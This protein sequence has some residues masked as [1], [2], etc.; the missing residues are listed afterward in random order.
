V[1]EKSNEAKQR[2]KAERDENV[3]MVFVPQLDSLIEEREK[4]L[5][6]GDGEARQRSIGK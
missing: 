5:L 1:I 6:D 3:I 2:K 4:R